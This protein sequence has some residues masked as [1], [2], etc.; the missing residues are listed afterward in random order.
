MINFNQHKKNLKEN[1]FSI[2]ENC[3]NDT[4]LNKI[5][6]FTE[7]NKFDFSERQVLN[8]FPKLKEIILRNDNFIKLFKS[9]CDESYFLSKAIYFNNANQ[10]L[11]IR[12]IKAATNRP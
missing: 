2:I 1:G 3:F 12:V 9:I 8:R 7:E 4:E 6:K 11:N 10:E 5:I